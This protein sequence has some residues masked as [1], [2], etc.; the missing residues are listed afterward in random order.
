M[1][2]LISAISL[3]IAS[4]PLSNVIQKQLANQGTSP[5]VI[6]FFTYFLLS[7][8]CVVFALGVNWAALSPSFWSYAMIGGAFGA[9]GNACLIKALQSGELSVLGPINAYKSVVGMI[10]AIFLLKEIPSFVG[11]A[12]II[13]IIAGSYFIF[14]T[15][16]EKFSP[17]VLLRK[18]IQFRILALIFTAI[19]AVFIKRVIIESS[20]LISFIV[21]CWFGALFS[22]VITICSRRNITDHLNVKN[23]PKYLL[24]VAFTGIMQLSTNFV[25]KRM[26][27]SY[28]LALFQLSALVSVFLGYKFFNEINLLKKVFGTIIMIA[29]SVI[30]IL[31]V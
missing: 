18:D 7:M 1:L 3:R 20:P 5:V 9:S 19:E 27:V 17:K 28:A 2:A 11:I 6:N 22:F 21:W 26:N 31:G 13:L 12:G 29:G 23:F 8:V 10:A 25:F 30:I 24:L 16:G 14:D 4:N 15:L